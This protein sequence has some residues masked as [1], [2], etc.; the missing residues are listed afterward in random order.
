MAAEDQTCLCCTCGDQVQITLCGRVQKEDLC[1]AGSKDQFRCNHCNALK[2]RITRALKDN[3]AAKEYYK[4]VQGED[5]KQLYKDAQ[6]LCGEEL[7]KTL[8]ESIT[9]CFIRKQSQTFTTEGDYMEIDDVKEKYKNKQVV[10][11]N[12][13]EFGARMTCQVRKV[14]MVWVPMY[15]LSFTTENTEIS[16]KKR[17]LESEKTIKG[18][19]NPK[20]EKVGKGQGKGE[21]F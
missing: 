5:R 2:A 9:K 17:K 16:C 7:T 1:S 4:D 20:K 10:L 11:K 6:K 12:I 8:F 14:E 15:K 21:F 18:E 19:K 3:D 13:L